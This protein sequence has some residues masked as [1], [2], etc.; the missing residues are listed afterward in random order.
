MTNTSMLLAMLI[1]AL[2]LTGLFILAVGAFARTELVR[3][4]RTRVD[5]PSPKIT[6]A[7]YLVSAV[8]NSLV[9]T[10][11]VFGVALGFATRLF[12]TGPVSPL[13]AVGEAAA[14]LAIYD[15]LYYL[16]HRFALHGWSVGRRIHAVHHTN[17]T[18]YVGDSV[19]IHP[20]E[21]A[22]GV[23]LFLVSTAIAGPVGM[24]SFGL[25][26]LVYSVLNLWIHSSVDLP[27]FPPSALVRHHD[28]H[29]ASMKAGHYASI[30]P[31]W[32][33]VFGTARRSLSAAEEPTS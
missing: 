13:R 31:L 16:L 19:Y 24:W 32:D 4:H 20:A 17:R 33:F 9:S 1:G 30:T 22:A 26:F 11:L 10:G 12:S 18:P 6:R 27:F 23:G 3:R 15:L 2:A 14:I 5:K 7:S 25:A 8:V 21:T 29:H 28:A